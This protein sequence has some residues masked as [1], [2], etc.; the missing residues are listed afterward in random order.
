M[1][2]INILN[3]SC[4]TVLSSSKKAHFCTIEKIRALLELTAFLCAAIV[5]VMFCWEHGDFN[6]PEFMLETDYIHWTTALPAISA[7]EFPNTTVFAA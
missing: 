1:S 5:A 4:I 2:L 7:C 3:E 6:S